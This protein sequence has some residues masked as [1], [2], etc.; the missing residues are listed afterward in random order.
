MTELVIDIRERR[1]RV[2][3]W[4][5]RHVV[6]TYEAAPEVA[7]RYADAMARRFAGLRITT[8]DLPGG[9]PATGSDLPGERL[10]PLTVK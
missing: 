8:E 3:V 2:Q 6:A 9:G 10:W 7:E 5:G 4:F 1:Q